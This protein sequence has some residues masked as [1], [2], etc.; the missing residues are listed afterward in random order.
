MKLPYELLNS[1]FEY[2]NNSYEKWNYYYDFNIH[3]LVTKLNKNF[4]SKIENVNKHKK[5][6]PTLFI[7]TNDEIFSIIHNTDM[8]I[9]KTYIKKT[10]YIEECKNNYVTYYTKTT[11]HFRDY[12]EEEE[13]NVFMW[14][15]KLE[16]GID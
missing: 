12:N 1:V 8:F 14:L 9:Q 6:F 3:K 11:L 5:K 10:V 15:E 2:N 4:F 16:Y 13:N 7:F